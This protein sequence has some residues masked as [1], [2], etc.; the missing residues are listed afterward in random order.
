MGIVVVSD[1]SSYGVGSV[2]Y[3]VFLNGSQKTIAYVSRP[4][5]PAEHNYSQI[6]KE[7]LIIVFAIK[8]FRK[9]LYRC[10]FTLIIDQKPL[11]IFGSKKSIPANTANRLQR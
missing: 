4:L 10:N 6:E 2:I 11:S 1:A 3:R 5:T 8:R 9:L 7:A